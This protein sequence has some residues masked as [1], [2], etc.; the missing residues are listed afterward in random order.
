MPIPLAD[1]SKIVFR[2]TAFWALSECGLG[3]ILHALKFPFSGILLCGI[4][5][6]IIFLIL[7]FSNCSW[8]PLIHA[9]VIVLLLKF[10]LSPHTSI[11][12]YFAVGFQAIISFMIYRSGGFNFFTILITTVIAYLETASHK[13]ITLTVFGGISFWKSADIFINKVLSEFFGL[14]TTHGMQYLL[15][16]Y[17]VIYFIAACIVGIF[18]YRIWSRLK[19]TNWEAMGEMKLVIGDTKDILNPKKSNNKWYWIFLTIGIL[20]LVPTLLLLT[21]NLS[22]EWL[23]FYLLRTV[24]LVI[25]WYY[26]LNPMII[27]FLSNKVQKVLPSMQVE[28]DDVQQLFPKLKLM[29][30]VAWHQAK[31]SKGLLRYEDFFYN[32]LLYIVID[33]AQE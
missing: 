1:N 31:S 25:L 32:L 30:A 17:F 28:I 3:G 12:A 19:L 24:G 23:G 29:I 4:S 8:K 13:L 15:I 7:Y 27:K 22:K 11:S 14:N 2:L 33:A 16:F 10:L 18:I 21:G 26:V 20:I 5:V 9:L 6:G